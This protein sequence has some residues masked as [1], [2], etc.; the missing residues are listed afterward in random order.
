ML[1]SELVESTEQTMLHMVTCDNM[2]VVPEFD[3]QSSMFHKIASC[4]E[5]STRKLSI[6][7]AA[8][9]LKSCIG[10]IH[11][12]DIL[13]PPFPKCTMHGIDEIHSVTHVG[14]SFPVKGRNAIEIRWM[15]EP[16]HSDGVGVQFLYLEKK[17]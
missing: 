8:D 11:N 13:W 6:T 7:A 14:V 12:C 4:H 5:T 15:R 1:I 3:D 17:R 9:L 16:R 10:N 2:Q